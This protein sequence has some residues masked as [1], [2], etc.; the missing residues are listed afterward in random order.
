MTQIQLAP[1]LN[2]IATVILVICAVVITGLVVRQ[3]FFLP[4]PGATIVQPR[5][6][7][8]ENEDWLRVVGE[9]NL[10]EKGGVTIVEFYD[11]QCPF[12]KR[13]L[14]A[15]KHVAETFGED[16]QL[17]RRHLPLEGIHAAAMPA[18]IAAECARDQGA[19]DAYH[20]VLFANQD[21]LSTNQNLYTAFAEEVGVE[22]NDMFKVCLT[23]QEPLETVQADAVL[24]RELGISSTPTLVINGTVYPGAQT[25]ESLEAIIRPLVQG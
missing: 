23:E 18:A 6:R 10:P 19:F 11:F 8:L 15:L 9:E 2:A 4:E 5:I 17:I 7:E 16:I 22:D 24:A 13:G 14:S 25:P 1:K 20:A 21:S 12:C 3:Q